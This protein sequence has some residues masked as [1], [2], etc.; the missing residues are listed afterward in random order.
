MHFSLPFFFAFLLS[1]WALGSVALPCRLMCFMALV[2]RWDH[3]EDLC[4]YNE[5]GCCDNSHSSPQG[6]LIHVQIQAVSETPR[7]AS[8]LKWFVHANTW[9][10]KDSRVGSDPKLLVGSSVS[11][12]GLQNLFAKAHVILCLQLYA[13]ECL[14]NEVCCLHAQELSLDFHAMGCSERQAAVLVS[15]LLL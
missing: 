7:H 8:A 15:E 10:N 1:W 6:Y 12:S 11:G 4:P 13:A 2:V 3:V 14:L 9:E 5:G